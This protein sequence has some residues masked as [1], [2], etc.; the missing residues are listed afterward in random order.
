M[1]DSH[2]FSTFRAKYRGVPVA[3]GLS[4]TLYSPFTSS[5]Y[6]SDLAASTHEMHISQQTWKVTGTI[7]DETGETLIGVSVLVKGTATGT[8]TD[9]DGKFSLDIPEGRKELEIS[10]VGY[11]TQTVTL[12][13]SSHITISL[14]PDLQALDEVVVIGY[15]TV[16]KRDLTGAISTVK[17]DVITMSPTINPMEALQGRV[18][19]LD[20]TRESAEAGEEIKM[21]LRGNR[22]ITA[23][24]DPLFIIDGM[25]GDYSTLNP[26]DIESIEILKDASSTAV[27]GS[28]G[29]NGVIII[30]TKK[31]EEGKM[32]V[33]FN[34]YVGF[35]GW[36]TLPTMMS[37]DKYVNTLREAQEIAGTY[38]DEA[39]LFS[40]IAI[41]ESYLRGENIDWAKALLKTSTVQNYSVS[42]SGGTQKTKAYFSLNY[43]GEDGQYK[44][45]DYKLYS[46]NIRVDHEVNKWLT[47]GI[48][49]QGSHAIRNRVY[50][51]MINVLTASPFGTLY[52]EEGNINP[53]PVA[54]NV[55]QANLLLNENK[56]A[57]RD[58][59]NAT[60]L[61]VNPYIRISPIKGL[62]IES[63]L[64][65]TFNFNTDNSFVGYGSY[66]FYDKLKNGALEAD[67]EAQK[68]VVYGSISNQRSWNY[69]WE[70]I[71]TYHFTIASDHDFTFTGVT[72]YNH[73]QRETS[74]MTAYGIT[75][76]QYRWSDMA[77]ATGS[78]T[79]ESNYTMS[80]EIGLTGRLS[81]SYLG[82][83]L[84][85]A[86]VRH[87]G[88]SR[89]AE[90]HKWSTFPAFSLGWRISD[91]SFMEGTESWLDNLKL[92]GGY[93]VTGTAGI[94]PYVSWAILQQK[95][96]TL[97]D[98][99]LT[100]YLYPENV[101][102]PL[103]TWERAHN[104]N[105]GL[106]IS[107]LNN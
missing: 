96:Y 10:Y 67:I 39:G 30:T 51:K 35:N 50:T 69:K 13:N 41:Y 31:G 52:D 98:E 104:T 95:N 81:Y 36:S 23:S 45:N 91:E 103:L 59:R 46:T 8:I 11:K 17:N 90:G 38:T 5:V 76:N 93:G 12:G 65:G 25:P 1:K 100:N 107:V 20:I 37:G 83:Y 84:F 15:G 97:G 66:Q 102:N 71:L 27:Y 42:V 6:A 92:R 4:L 105:I 75:S 64:N 22:S 29:A 62:T 43:S 86:S 18:A 106:D 79:L 26:N 9:I 85:S 99:K 61:Y 68:A 55:D 33:N 70:N 48:S 94:D 40:D 63:R 58:E 24:G 73:N 74:K 28:S 34:A 7:L 54:G 82:K 2:L 56:D 60:K 14:Q 88:S 49:M 101:P 16:K 89:L 44:N 72:S 21:Q 77:A 78:K 87:D 19:G 32:R 53:F 3:I 80:K 57:Y 47:A